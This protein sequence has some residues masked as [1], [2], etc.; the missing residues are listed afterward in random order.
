VA[1]AVVV[2][3]LLSITSIPIGCGNDD[4]GHGPTPTPTTV[5]TPTAAP[6]SAATPTPTPLPSATV[7]P[8]PIVQPV[9]SPAGV[10]VAGSASGFLVAYGAAATATTGAIYG[11]RLAADGTVRDETGFLISVAQSGGYLTDP[12]WTAPAVGFDGTSYGVVY[13]GTGTTE[14]IFAAAITAVLV[15]DEKNVGVPTDL[16]ETAQFGM[17]QSEVIAPPAISGTP[18][19]TFGA[20]WP[21]LEGCVNVPVIHRLDG[22]F[23]TP[24]GESLSVV[25]IQGLLPPFDQAQIQTS[26]ASVASSASTTVAAWT[27]SVPGGADPVVEVAQLATG[28]VERTQL[29]TGAA[30]NFRPAIASDGSDYLVVW[31]DASGAI[32]GGRFR[33]GTGPLDGPAGFV[34][35]DDVSALAPRVAFGDGTYL[36]AFFALAGSGSEL[37]TFAVSPAGA[38]TSIETQTSGDTAGRVAVAFS[39]GNFLV[40]YSV[41]DSVAAVLIRP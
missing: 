5:A 30:G 10:D 27:E 19:S 28:G 31:Q 16:A 20:L 12:S 14:G 21:L 7:L 15:D 35:A 29:A 34:I 23:A 26:P 38:V 1:T 9:A 18:A 25:E 8:I 3:C 33:P 41:L 36:V 6:T 32:R 40:A 11:V 13:A 37:E 4:G 22:A 17:C 24:Q 2:T 39:D